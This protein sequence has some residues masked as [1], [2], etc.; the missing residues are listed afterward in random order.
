MAQR[1]L[2]LRPFSR[3]RF[4]N[5]V[6]QNRKYKFKSVNDTRGH[7]AGDQALRTLTAVLRSAGLRKSDSWGR[8]GGEEFAVTLPECSLEQAAIVA[9]RIR[10]RI[11]EAP[12]TFGKDVFFITASIG[13]S[14]YRSGD[15]QETLLHRAD[16]AL[17]QAKQTGRNRVCLTD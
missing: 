15:T 10:S 11:A 7:A 5:A 14:E 6:A 9:E 2:A 16:Q 1:K 17:Y 3:K 4:R 8:I 12:V 13:L